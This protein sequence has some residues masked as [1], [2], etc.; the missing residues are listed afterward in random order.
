[1]G[2]RRHLDGTTSHLSCRRRR[3]SQLPLSTTLRRS[4]PARTAA[5]AHV[6]SGCSCNTSVLRCCDDSLNLRDPNPTFCTKSAETHNVTDLPTILRVQ[7]LEP[8]KELVHGFSTL[9]LGSV[10]VKDSRRRFAE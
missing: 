10:K 7:G 1:M 8:E 2:P 5:S 9:D 4:P 6:G 3:R